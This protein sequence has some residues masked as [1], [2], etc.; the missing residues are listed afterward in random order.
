MKFNEYLEI[1]KDN[2]RDQLKMEQYLNDN[3]DWTLRFDIQKETY[4]GI[5]DNLE[6]VE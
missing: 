2:R 6:D 3:I 1:S 4:K 5:I